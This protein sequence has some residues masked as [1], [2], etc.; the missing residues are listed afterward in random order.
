MSKLVNYYNSVITNDMIDK[1]NYHSVESIPK[2]EK[3][4]INVSF[5]EAL[6]DKSKWFPVLLAL[7]LITGDKYII[8]K[9]RQSISSFRLRQNATIGCKVVLKDKKMYSFLENLVYLGLPKIKLFEGFST[10]SFDPK[11]NYSFSVNE[12]SIFYELEEQLEMFDDLTAF[13]VTIVFDNST[14]IESK[15][16]LSAF[17]I[18]F[19]LNK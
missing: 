5:K 10:K 12:T 6:T 14:V 8:R 11:G 2:M 7:Q 13:N 19:K 16:L 1:F 18:P 9:A 3:I 15:I 4:V 17:Q